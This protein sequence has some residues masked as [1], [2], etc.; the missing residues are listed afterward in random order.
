MCAWAIA[1]TI[2]TRGIVI[3]GEGITGTTGIG[4]IAIAAGTGAITIVGVDG[5]TAK[6]A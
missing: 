6:V 2:T 5:A 3:I 1:I 4:S